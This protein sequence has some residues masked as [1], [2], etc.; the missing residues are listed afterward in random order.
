MNNPSQASERDL[1]GD[2]T[3]GDE[4]GIVTGSA[5]ESGSPEREAT[6]EEVMAARTAVIGHVRSW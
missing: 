1:S 5:S 6:T 2:L 3:T 4:D